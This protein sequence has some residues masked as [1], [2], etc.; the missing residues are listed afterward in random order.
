[1]RAQRSKGEGAK[2]Q[3][4][5]AACNIPRLQCVMAARSAKTL[6]SD[7]EY[8]LSLMSQIGEDSES[9]DDFDGWLNDHRERNNETGSA[10]PCR[11]SMSLESPDAAHEC[12]SLT[13][14]PM[15]LSTLSP[16]ASPTRATLLGSATP[17]TGNDTQNN[18][19]LVLLHSL[20]KLESFLTLK[21]WCL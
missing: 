5:T 13:H 3:Q 14:S 4:P 2:L 8:L 12:S 18:L 16:T 19:F 17:P 20:L 21:A 10:P 11:R 7:P 9:D 1:M 6:P 15:Q